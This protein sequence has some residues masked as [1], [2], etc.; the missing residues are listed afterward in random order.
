ME[1]KEKIKR[2]RQEEYT[3]KGE[4]GGENGREFKNLGSQQ[5]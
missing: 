1:E 2:T 3:Q 5:C 4:V